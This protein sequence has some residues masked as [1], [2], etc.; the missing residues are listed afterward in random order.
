MLILFFDFENTTLKSQLLGWSEHAK[1][2]SNRADKLH[3]ELNIVKL[4]RVLRNLKIFNKLSG[5]KDEIRFA[6]KNS[7]NNIIDIDKYS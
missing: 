1:S 2:E 6:I 3:Q 7:R 5:L 4:I